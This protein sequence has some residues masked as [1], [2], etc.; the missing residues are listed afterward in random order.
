WDLDD[1]RRALL[2]FTRR[3]LALRR[4]LPVV[5]MDAFF[6]GEIWDASHTDLRWYHSDGSVLPKEDWT[7]PFLRSLQMLFAHTSGKNVLCLINADPDVK[8]FT[9]PPGSGTWTARLDTRSPD[10]PPDTRV[11]AGET[12]GM[13]G[14][15]M[16]VLVTA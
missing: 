10:P 7:R 2:G 4:E 3:L 14:R 6:G 12:Y 1:A 8:P 13:N 11:E 9:I 15:A 5:S 16:A